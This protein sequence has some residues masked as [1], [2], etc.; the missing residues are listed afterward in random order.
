MQRGKNKQVLLREWVHMRSH[1]RDGFNICGGSNGTRRNSK[2]KMTDN[3]AWVF[4]S[5][6][7]AWGILGA[8][9]IENKVLGEMR[10]E[11]RQTV[12]QIICKILKASDIESIVSAHLFYVFDFWV[13]TFIISNSHVS[14]SLLW[15][16]TLNIC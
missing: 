12:S 11:T 6:W 2:C 15:N 9:Y 5:T 4:L 13:F 10:T 14:L 1:L 8:E 3:K 7:Y 16:L